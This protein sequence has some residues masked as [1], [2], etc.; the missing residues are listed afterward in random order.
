MDDEKEFPMEK[1]DFKKDFKTLYNPP[2]KGFAFVDV[3][4]LKY[5]MIERIVGFFCYGEFT[6]GGLGRVCR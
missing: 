5:L 4:A 3:P 6:A 2:A 1:I